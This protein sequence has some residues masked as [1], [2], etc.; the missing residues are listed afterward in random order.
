M[1]IETDLSKTIRVFQAKILNEA[2]EDAYGDCK[3]SVYD[4]IWDKTWVKMFK[5][6]SWQIKHSI[7]GKIKID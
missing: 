6:F 1:L 7:Y 3:E 2:Q 4:E 5:I